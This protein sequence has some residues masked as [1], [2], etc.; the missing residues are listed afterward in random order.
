V[1]RLELVA[2]KLVATGVVAFLPTLISSPAALYHELIPKFAHLRRLLGDGDDGDGGCD[3]NRDKVNGGNGSGGNSSGGGRELTPPPPLTP[4]CPP[5]PPSRARVLGL[6]LE[7]PFM[8]VL[9]KGAHKAEY[10]R[11]PADAAAVGSAGGASAGGGPSGCLGGLLATYG[12]LEGVK[13]VTLAP[14]LEGALEATAGLKASGV[15]VSMGHTMATF[16]QGVAGVRHGAT[17]VTHLFNAMP[18]FHHRD[19]GLVGLLGGPD[20]DRCCYSLI[21][22]GLHAHAASVKLASCSHP[23]GAVLVTDAV[24]AMGLPDG[25]HSLGEHVTVHKAGNRAT[26]V[27][28][29]GSPTDTLAGAVV[30]LDACL[31]NYLAF[32]QCSVPEA[33]AAASSRPHALLHRARQAATAARRRAR[34]LPLPPAA[35]GPSLEGDSG[36]GDSDAG[37][38]A[39]GG[40]DGGAADEDACVAGTLLPGADADLVLLSADD[41]EVLATFRN[42]R[43]IWDKARGHL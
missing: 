13:L 31:R 4:Q 3:G 24:A 14:E 9:K 23:S 1:L 29:D 17:L 30:P 43:R 15:V 19:P 37:G 39:E 12:S 28:A 27:G 18:A 42:G 2:R 32:T 16:D 21:A 11:A 25:R 6:H 36:P 8:S 10:M 40:A 35:T 20:R 22:D 5:V 34:T 26:V 33:V 7:G 38:G 41:L